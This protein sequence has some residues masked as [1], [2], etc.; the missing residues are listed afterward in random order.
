MQDEPMKPMLKSPGIKRLRLSYDE[1][2]SNFAFKFNLRRYIGG[3]TLVE[4]T[5]LC[6]NALKVRRCSLTP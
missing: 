3:P 1:P 5:S 2:P 6:Y 4:D